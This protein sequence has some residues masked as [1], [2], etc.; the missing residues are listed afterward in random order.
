MV[1]DLNLA[2]KDEIIK[3]KQE[4][5]VLENKQTNLKKKGKELLPE[6]EDLNQLKVLEDLQENELFIYGFLD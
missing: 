6:E 4:I 5:A 1:E 3:T 2:P